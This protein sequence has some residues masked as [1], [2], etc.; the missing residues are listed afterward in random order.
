MLDNSDWSD[1]FAPE[2]RFLKEGEIIRRTNLSRTLATIAQD[3][4][5]AFYKGPIADSILEKARVTG[6]I[7]SQSDLDHYK[8]Q[9]RPALQGS[10]RGRRVYTTHAPTSGPGK[11]LL[12]IQRRGSLRRFLSTVA[13]AQLDGALRAPAKERAQC[14]QN[15]RNHEVWIRCPVRPRVHKMFALVTISQDENMRPELY[16]FVATN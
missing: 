11:L 4:P 5:D 16:Q 13:Y 6:G 12:L 3:G 9:V 1:I 15:R 2:G 10:Y 7:L 8:V 14:P